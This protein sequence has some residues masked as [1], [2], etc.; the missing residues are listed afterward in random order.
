[1]EDAVEDEDAHF[2]IEGA[3]EALGV[4][5]GDGGGDGDV[6]EISGK[7]FRC[8][9]G[10]G[11]GRRETRGALAA[12]GTLLTMLSCSCGLCLGHVCWEG[13]YIGRAIFATVGAIPARDLRIGDESDGERAGREAQAFAGGGEKFLEAGNGNTNATLLIEDHAREINPG[14]SAGRDGWSVPS[15]GHCGADGWRRARRRP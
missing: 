12:C 6:S 7:T 2:V 14:D 3:A 4:A 11:P 15:R 5:A 9:R 8:R 1:M 10:R 13:Q